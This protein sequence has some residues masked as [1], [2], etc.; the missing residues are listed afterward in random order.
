MSSLNQTATA[1][2]RAAPRGHRVVPRVQGGLLHVAEQPTRAF[3][4]TS[5]GAG[6]DEG[7]QPEGAAQAH[8]ADLAAHPDGV[9][10]SGV[11]P[12]AEEQA[13]AAKELPHCSPPVFAASV[14]LQVC[15]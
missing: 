4:P 9:R 13:D 8:E 14:C 5:R 10:L 3:V 2:D 15:V 7:A 6:A 12:G 11:P 1:P